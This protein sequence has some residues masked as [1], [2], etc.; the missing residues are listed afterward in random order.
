MAAFKDALGRKWSIS[1]DV[2]TI[3]R[4]RELTGFELLSIVENDGAALGKLRDDIPLL[5][6][7]LYAIVEPQANAYGPW[8]RR[9]LG[10]GRGITDEE[11]GRGLRGDC[12][13]RAWELIIGELAA[14]FP[15]G[16]R[17]LLLAAAIQSGLT[18]KIDEQTKQRILGVAQPQMS[19]GSC[20]V[21]RVLSAC[22]PGRTPGANSH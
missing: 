4:V 20:S 17:L 7:V 9:L 10:I 16:R 11:F 21:W 19:G 6:D 15:E 2:G 5:V 14:F 3:K 18:I 12:I 22:R 8:W 1:I 13:E